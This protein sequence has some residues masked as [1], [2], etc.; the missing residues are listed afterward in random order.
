MIYVLS[1]FVLCGRSPCNVH[2]TIPGEWEANAVGSRRE[3]SHRLR[4]SSFGARSQMWQWCFVS[5]SL[6]HMCMCVKLR[7]LL[8]FKLHANWFRFGF[9]LISFC[10]FI[11]FYFSIFHRANLLRCYVPQW[12]ATPTVYACFWSTEL[13]QRPRAGWVY[14]VLCWCLFMDVGIIS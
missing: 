2:A 9:P 3:R 5:G 12:E 4:A 13:T 7:F 11:V 1:S 8:V 6:L 10:I 14:C